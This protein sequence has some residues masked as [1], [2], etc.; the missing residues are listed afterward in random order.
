MSLATS[1]AIATSRS[2]AASGRAASRL[3]GL[4]LAGCLTGALLATPALADD[5]PRQIHVQA[6]S[7]LDVAPDMA[8]LNASLWERTPAQ[9]R[10]QETSGDSDA[11]KQARDR[12]E[13]RTGDLI[14]TLENAGV[15][16]R[17]IRAGSLSVSP[18]IM[19]SGNGDDATQQ[20]R[21][22]V[23]RSVS[24]KLTDL[25]RLPTV[26]DALTTAGVD[27]LDGVSYG[28][29]DSDS[30]DDRA[31]KQALERARQKAEM[32][33]DTLDVDLGDVISIEETTSP[34]YQPKAMMMR[35]T[36]ADSGGSASEYRSGDISVD[37]GVSVIWELD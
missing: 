30:V 23:E 19:Q 1:R 22:R 21:T 5:T 25:D 37:A 33:A 24:L 15:D 32:M 26:L 6:E 4:G 12:L 34:R 18:E 31:L 10:G 8:T 11:I 17:N 28:L 14:R 29:Q 35:A 13:S 2:L 36:A 9:P 27:S 20:V 16:T 3:L 7:T